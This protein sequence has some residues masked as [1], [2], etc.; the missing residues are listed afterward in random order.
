MTAATSF[1]IASK[2]PC[3]LGIHV[4]APLEGGLFRCLR[5]GF[6]HQFNRVEVR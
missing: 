5:C 6:T 1:N 4:S 3:Q 2:T